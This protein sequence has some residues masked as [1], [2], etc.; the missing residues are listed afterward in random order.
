MSEII[1]ATEATIRLAIFLGVL[2]AMALWEVP[3]P[4]GVGGK[5]RE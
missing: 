5:S 3:A 2:A 1:L 4:P